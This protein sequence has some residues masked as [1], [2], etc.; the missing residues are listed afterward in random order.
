MKPKI[1][2][3][4]PYDKECYISLE[5]NGNHVL[6]KLVDQHNIDLVHNP[7][8]QFLPHKEG[9]TLRLLLKVGAPVSEGDEIYIAI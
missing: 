5:Q 7:I 1:F 3:E 6:I 4:L 2:T 9:V 8:L